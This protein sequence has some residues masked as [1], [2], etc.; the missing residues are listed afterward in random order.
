VVVTVVVLALASAASAAPVPFTS[1]EITTPA[2]GSFPVL[3]LDAPNTIHVQGTTAGGDADNL[4]D[5]LCYY[6]TT[7]RTLATD[8]AVTAGVI[9]AVLPLTPLAGNNPRPYCVLRAVPANDATI[10][11]PDMA[12]PAFAGPHVGPAGIKL[13]KVGVSGINQDVVSDY[14]VGGAQ[15]KGYMEYDS[16]G[17][18][19]VDWSFVFDPVT[20]A[21]SD[22]F[23]YCAG[24][25]NVRNGCVTADVNALCVEATRSD[26]K[27]DGKHAYLPASAR[28]AF[29]ADPSHA[30]GTLSGYPLLS[31]SSFFDPLTGDAHISETDQ[32]AV[33]SPNPTA[34]HPAHNDP[35]WPSDCSSFAPSGVKVERTVTGDNNGR[36]STFV[37]VWSSTDGKSHQVDVLY[38]EEFHGDGA[39]IPSPSFDYSWDGSGFIGPLAGDTVNGPASDA[40]ATILIDGNG[41]TPDA[42][43]FPQ[44]AMTFS[45]APVAVH[46]WRA[47]TFVA[48]GDARFVFTVPREGSVTFAH[49][50]LQ[51]SDK[52]EISAQIPGE[53]A[54]IGRPHVVV[55]SP[56]EDAV[57]DTSAVTVTGTASDPAG[58]LTGLTVNGDAVTVAGDGSWSK[59]MALSQGENKITAVGTD[60]SGNT[61][62]VISHVTYTPPSPPAE[63]GS[64]G[65]PP[66]GA[67]ADKVAPL[68]GLT[69]ARTKLGALLRKGL[70]VRVRC[71]EPCAFKVTLVLDRKTGRRV[72]LAA[73]S[74]TV[75]RGSGRLTVAGTKKVFVKLSKQ[76]KKKLR[77]ARSFSLSVK[78]TA[79]DLAGNVATKSKKV[80]VRR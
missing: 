55:S 67:T 25:L 26:L 12:S 1:S 20:F 31:V 18:C 34:Y 47:G 32:T 5:L 35:A 52:P 59:P 71:S 65:P 37:D 33:C 15:S 9:D 7:S 78:L 17:G 76:A 23:Y 68:L 8:V 29:S 40:P 38:D 22:E 4:A 57:V 54:R 10:Y 56:A 73:A 77:K 36:R 3:N 64:T 2:D 43:Q 46:W 51:G 6:G 21:Q 39:T 19:G 75:G 80:A 49:S 48:Y 27:V 13:V 11:P 72:G 30:P 45:M 16:V 66:P 62:T 53:Q 14:W 50:Y 58:G 24:W 28:N 41:L 60:T 63:G 79:H 69:I 70:P 74:L 44:G 61:T 42:F